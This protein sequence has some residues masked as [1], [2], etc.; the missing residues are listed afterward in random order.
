LKKDE[1]LL[2]IS[3]TLSAGCSD[4]PTKILAIVEKFIED[5]CVSGLCALERG[6]SFEDFTCRWCVGL[7]LKYVFCKNRVC[8]TQ[9]NIVEKVA[10]FC[11]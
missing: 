3:I 10:T 4:I 7:D 9:N 5:R 8:L 11:I 2:K 6:R 1:K